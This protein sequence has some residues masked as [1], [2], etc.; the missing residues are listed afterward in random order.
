[1]TN[2]R[3]QLGS[4]VAPEADMTPQELRDR[5][6]AHALAVF[7]LTRPL[8]RE[9]SSR[10][11]ADQL[12]RA[13]TAVA[14]NY[15]SACLGRSTPEFAAKLGV[16][17]EEA[18]ETVFWLE[19]ADQAGLTTGPTTAAILVEARELTAIF[20][21]AYRTTKAKLKKKKASNNK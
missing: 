14:A 1:L 18:D 8:M 15:R 11:V 9:P 12:F 21:A 5:T 3:R 17:R 19:F 4:A 7:R 2:R 16:V 20:S 13:A 6:M 10:H